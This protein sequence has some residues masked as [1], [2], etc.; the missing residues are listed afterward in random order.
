MEAGL[1]ID[2]LKLAFTIEKSGHLA[3]SLIV[4]LRLYGRH[5]RDSRIHFL[6]ETMKHNSKME[7][8]WSA[9]SI[10][11]GPTSATKK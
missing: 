2:F 3:W 10:S 1:C 7:N 11:I 4:T 6:N 8:P 9:N 5:K